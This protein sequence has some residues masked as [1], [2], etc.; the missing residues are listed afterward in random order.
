MHLL[1]VVIADLHLQ[2]S[3]LLHF[4]SSHG[5][6]E[7]REKGAR[8][9]WREEKQ[10]MER[11]RKWRETGNGEKQKMERKRNEKEREGWKGTLYV[12]IIP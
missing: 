11:N 6:S 4:L 10:E 12:C 2:V 1:P 3:Q 5:R 7:M 9:N 8:G